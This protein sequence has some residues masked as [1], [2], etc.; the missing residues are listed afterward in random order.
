[1][2]IEDHFG[3][4]KVKATTPSKKRGKKTK[5]FKKSNSKYKVFIRKYPLRFELLF[6]QLN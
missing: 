2:S 4:L 5:A 6:S 1:L 3:A